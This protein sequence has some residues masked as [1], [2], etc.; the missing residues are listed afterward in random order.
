MKIIISPAKKMNVR[1]DYLEI[2]GL[3]DYLDRTRKLM[4]YIKSLNYQ[5]VKKIWGCNDK[6]AALNF[7]RFKNMNLTKRLTP[8][9]FSY[10]GLQYQYMAPHV[11]SLS[12]LEYVQNHLFILSGFY[13]ALKPLDGVVPYRLEMQAKIILADQEREYRDLYTFLGD[14]IYQCVAR[15]Q[16]QQVILNLASKEYSK[17]I[18]KYIGSD[19]AF[20]NCIFGSL[21]AGKNDKVKVK[22]TE[23]KMARGEMVRF[24]A[25]YNIDDTEGVKR[26]NRLGYQYWKDM[27]DKNNFVFVKKTDTKAE[28]YEWMD[29]LDQDLVRDISADGSL[30]LNPQGVLQG[31]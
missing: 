17:A 16:E 8:A 15:S 10:E 30:C 1:E 31:E 19:T 12:E 26:F 14:K 6:I 5:E 22:G 11:F 25:E 21:D 4:E 29:S 20:I 7:E 13:G 2:S 27:S 3:P 24:L 9:I 23:A 18:E 28:I